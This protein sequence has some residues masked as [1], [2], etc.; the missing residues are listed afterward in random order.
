MGGDFQDNQMALATTLVSIIDGTDFD[1]TE[2]MEPI[3]YSNDYGKLDIELLP[4]NLQ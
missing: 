1:D 2:I 4:N 3:G